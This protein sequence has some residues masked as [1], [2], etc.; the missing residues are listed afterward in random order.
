ME[1]KRK[2]KKVMRQRQSV[3]RTNI[4]CNWNPKSRGEKL[5]EA[6]FEQIVDRNF[7]KLMKDTKPR[8]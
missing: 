6:I 1:E 4:M 8:I 3:R 5:T 7:Q 2:Q